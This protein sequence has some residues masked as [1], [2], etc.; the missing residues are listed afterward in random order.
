MPEVNRSIAFIGDA[1]A[2][3]TTLAALIYD[4]A[5]RMS[6]SSVG[7]ITVE[8]GLTAFGFLD[9]ILIPL[10]TGRFPEATVKDASNLL[11][12]GLT[13]KRVI[14][15]DHSLLL[16][17]SDLPG[18]NVQEVGESVLAVDG[19]PPQQ[20]TE[21]LGRQ[22]TLKAMFEADV[23]VLVVD[24]DLVWK[25]LEENGGRGG[26]QQAIYLAAFRAYKRYMGQR[27]RAVIVAMTKFDLVRYI[28]PR[29][30]VVE[31]LCR[32]FRSSRKLMI[33]PRTTPISPRI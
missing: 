11:E 2:G 29:A 31:S 23:I 3:K 7:S 33:I 18:V 12:L 26:L 10:R 14:G 20:F 28:M 9:R 32:R 25:D 30:I 4:A 8:P 19:Q 27:A 5:E 1:A 24:A 17:F 13:Y 22:A 15:K 16:R 6:L 21:A